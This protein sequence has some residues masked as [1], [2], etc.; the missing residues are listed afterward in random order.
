MKKVDKE[1][2]SNEINKT[3]TLIF[4]KVVPEVVQSPPK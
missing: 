4:S 2:T 1:K 3:V